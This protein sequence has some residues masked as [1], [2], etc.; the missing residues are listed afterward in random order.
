[1][2][3]GYN[4]FKAAGFKNLRQVLGKVGKSGIVKAYSGQSAN[5]VN[6]AGNAA[7]ANLS[8]AAPAAAPGSFKRGGWVRR[9]GYAKVHKGEF[10]LT[11]K[12]AK[13]YKKKRRTRRRSRR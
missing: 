7:N 5:L 4:I 3:K 9:T 12:A 10:V 2:G 6:T 1:M 8:A 13:R 11:R